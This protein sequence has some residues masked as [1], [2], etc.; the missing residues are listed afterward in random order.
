MP[1]ADLENLEDKKESGLVIQTEATANKKLKLGIFDIWCLGITVVIGGQYFSWNAGLAA[2]FGSFLISTILIGTSYISLCCCN[3]EVTSALPFAGG[4]Y[5]IA[6]VSLGL[7]PGFII[8]CLEAIEYI[9]YVAETS[10][11][12]GEMICHLSHVSN[13]FIPVYSLVFYITA[14]W[15]QI[16]GGKVFWRSNALM[17]IASIII[18]LIFCFGSLP[19]VD[20]TNASA[21]TTT[22]HSEVAYFIGGFRKFLTVMPLA[23]WW[24]VGIESLNL[25]C[26]FVAEVN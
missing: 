14:V 25:S 9:I 2:G 24:Y 26:A 8:G 18:L 19:W 21:T 23:A 7:Y 15:I 5:G 1:Q 4:A 12:L 10:H 22:G 11:I 6:R 16:Q 17:A 13:D 3:A 20:I